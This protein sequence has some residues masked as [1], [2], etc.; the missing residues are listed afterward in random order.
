MS[1]TGD[2]KQQPPDLEDAAAEWFCRLNEAKGKDRATVERSFRQWMDAD[3]RHAEAFANVSATWD[4][5]GQHAAEPEFLTLRQSA[6]ADARFSAQRRW[7]PSRLPRWGMAGYAAAALLVASGY[8]FFSHM[9]PTGKQYSTQIGQREAL[10]LADNSHVD[11]DADSAVSIALQHDMRL[12]HL[13]HGQAYFQVAK[14]RKRPFIVQVNGQQVIATGTAFNVEA[15]N[16]GLRVTLVEGHVV[17]RSAPESN[18]RTDPS[19]GTIIAKL[20]PGDQLTD[21]SGGIAHLDHSANVLSVTAWRQGKLIFTNDKLSDIVA[22]MKHYSTT[23][24]VITDPEIAN[25]RV[26]GV[27]NAGDIPALVDALRRF[28]PI[29]A[30]SDGPNQVRLAPR[31]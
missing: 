19:E 9:Q 11:I 29:Q 10:T 16:G 31:H 27:F 26:S 8:Y 14:D 4:A 3:W 24:I 12:I 7:K 5:I 2:A 15:I 20:S 18:V 17:V 25:L 30:Y 28:F 13:E 23:E 21:I 1:G 22:C 6:L